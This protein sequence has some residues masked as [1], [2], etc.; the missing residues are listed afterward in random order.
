MLIWACCFGVADAMCTIAAAM[1]FNEPFEIQGKRMPGK[2][3]KYAGDRFSDHVALLFAFEEWQRIR[4]GGQ[5][6]EQ[7]WCENK[8][9]LYTVG[10]AYKSLHMDTYK[11]LHIFVVDIGHL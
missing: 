11:S 4:E 6:K 8:V 5:D 3:R 7:S 9:L 10:A 1:C 2:H